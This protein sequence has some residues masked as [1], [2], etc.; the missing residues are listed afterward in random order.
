[1]AVADPR[2]DAGAFPVAMM[3]GYSECGG[4]LPNRSLTQTLEGDNRV[5]A[6][7][8]LGLTG[9]KVGVSAINSAPPNQF[10]DAGSSGFSIYRWITLQAAR[11]TVPVTSGFGDKA[12]NVRIKEITRFIL[13][14]CNSNAALMI[15]L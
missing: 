13:T 15:T 5:S 6:R 1:M 7:G 11:Q 3:D 4:H 9:S 2:T 8:P 14:P 10:L 12:A